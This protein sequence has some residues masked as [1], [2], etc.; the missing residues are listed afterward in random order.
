MSSLRLALKLSLEGVSSSTQ[1]KPKFEDDSLDDLKTTRVKKKRS[2]SVDEL[3][4]HT[5][6]NDDDGVHSMSKF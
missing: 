2:L 3:E 4:R 1:Q 5:S 6:K